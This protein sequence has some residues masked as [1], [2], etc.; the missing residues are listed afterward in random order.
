MGIGT[1]A[2]AVGKL[3]LRELTAKLSGR[4]IDFVQLALSKAIGDI[5][6]E[7]GTLRH[8]PH[9]DISLEEVTDAALDETVA[10]VRSMKE[11]LD[12]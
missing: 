12:R 1:L 7:T 2:H 5:R 3:P 6:T 9:A 4:G 11:A 8:K 10:L